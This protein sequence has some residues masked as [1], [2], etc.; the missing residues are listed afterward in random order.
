M[1]ARAARQLPPDMPTP[2]SLQKVNPADQPILFLALGS[3]TLPLSQVNEYAETVIAQRLSTVTGVAQVNINGAQKFAVRIDLDP[4][5][6]ASRQIGID[7]VAQAVQQANSNLP[8]G[9]LAGPQQ[10]FVVE[11]DGKLMSAAAYRPVVVAYRNGSPV[12]LYEVAQR[13]STAWRTTR[14]GPISERR[15][16]SSSRSSAS[17]APTRSQIIDS[18][19]ALLP[20]AAGAAAR[21]GHAGRPQRPLEVDPRVGG[22]RE[23]HAGAHDGAGGAGDL[24]LPPQRLRDRDPQ[25]GAAGLG[26]RHVRGDVRAS[27]T[28]STTCR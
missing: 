25:P 22:R 5:E 21:L 7:Q 13:L 3:D 26:R 9:T 28:A 15:A 20:A 10:S 8:T 6:L 23:V 16:P 11:A 14:P 27:A 4:R 24:P 12:R 1:I 2:P 17:P 19:R 18:I